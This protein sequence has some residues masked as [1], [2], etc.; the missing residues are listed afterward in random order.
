MNLTLA[1][2][3][4]FA[5][6][7]L[8]GRA[9][10][11]TPES[12]APVPVP[13]VTPPAEPALPPMPPPDELLVVLKPKVEVIRTPVRLDD[14]ADLLG[15]AAEVERFS[16]LELCP[17]PVAGKPRLVTPAGVRLAARLAGLELTRERVV[18]APQVE[19]VANWLEL[20]PDD[21]ANAAQRWLVERNEE[22]GDKILVEPATKAD[23]IALLKGGGAATFEHFFVGRPRGTGQVQVK[24]S[25]FQDGT[26]LGERVATFNVRR[27]GRQLRL[28]TNVRR[29][30]KVAP[31]QV[32]VIEG[33]W[34]TVQGTPVLTPDTLQGLV[35]S[36]ELAAGAVLVRESFE[37]PLLVDR[38]GSVSVVLQS[39]A[40]QIV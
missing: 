6:S 24:S 34:T 40:L 10:Q 27:F 1:W 4:S 14:V 37:L 20:S 30:E 2:L 21:L 22:L 23:P 29:G 11:E 13:H 8:L 5:L 28:L 19:I 3:S 35:A 17:A 39:G 12:P 38:G 16:R 9:P 33:E 31:S 18:G 36:R 26:L 32:A 7:V 15:P 25:I